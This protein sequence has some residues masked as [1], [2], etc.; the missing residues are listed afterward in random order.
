MRGQ[1]RLVG[2]VEG[3]QPSLGRGSIAHPER[4]EERPVRLPRMVSP[5]NK[6]ITPEG[7]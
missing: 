3:V 4:M 6:D 7:S 5:L 2:S 1:K